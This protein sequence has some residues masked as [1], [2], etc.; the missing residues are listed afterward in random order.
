MDARKIFMLKKRKD[1]NYTFD[2]NFSLDGK[3]QLKLQIDL[4]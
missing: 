4:L 2:V 3:V 1:R